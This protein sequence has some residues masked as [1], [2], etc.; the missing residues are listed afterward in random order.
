MDPQER[1]DLLVLLVKMAALA[2][3]DLLDPEASLVTLDSLALR[4]LGVSLANPERR[5]PLV[6]LV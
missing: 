5:D 3:L 2:P 6:L 1:R 4:D